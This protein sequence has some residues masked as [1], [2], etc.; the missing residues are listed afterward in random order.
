MSET[1]IDYA[2][3]DEAYR[4]F[5]AAGKEGWDTAEGT[6]RSLAEW[7]RVLQAD[8]VPR[9][10][11]AL[12]LGCGAGDLSL[13][14]AQRGYDVSGVDISPT[15]IDWA[16]EKAHA[17]GLQAAFR[18]GNV[19]DLRDYADDQFDIVVDGHCLHCIIGDDRQAFLKSGRRVLRPSGCFVVKTM[20]GEPVN[21]WARTHFD[22]ETRRLVR[23]DGLVI[24]YLGMPED[25][26]QEVTDSGL[27]VLD[28]KVIAAS[29]DDDQDN[30]WIYATHERPS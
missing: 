26:L 10:G 21:A 23:E 30:V 7:E 13:W 15:A 20:C 18:V 3:H 16:R 1:R 25:I 4:K 27:W 8:H 11:R 9:S 12:E 2:A 17:R 28:W 5:K 19:V 14:L 6:E 22:P 29:S 24:R